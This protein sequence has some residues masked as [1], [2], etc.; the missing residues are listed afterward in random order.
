MFRGA[1][2]GIFPKIYINRKSFE[3]NI[4]IGSLHWQVTSSI[5][6]TLQECRN[7]AVLPPP[8]SQQSDDDSGE[9][10][11]LADPFF[12][13]VCFI[14]ATQPLRKETSIMRNILSMNWKTLMF[15]ISKSQAIVQWDLSKL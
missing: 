3:R 14:T 4:L 6:G 15:I 8:P 9:L 12:R 7:R 13:A 5:L 2:I 11:G 1:A 10:Q